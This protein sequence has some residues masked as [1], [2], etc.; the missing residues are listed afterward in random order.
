MA[1]APALVR[2]PVALFSAPPAQVAERVAP[3]LLDEQYASAN[4]QFF[5]RGRSINPPPYTQDREAQERLWEVS[6][7]LARLA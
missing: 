6:E 5:H 1:Q 4:G 3:L 2:I 7:Q